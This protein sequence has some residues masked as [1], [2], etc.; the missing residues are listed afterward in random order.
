VSFT[1]VFLRCPSLFATVLPLLLVLSGFVALILRPLCC[2]CIAI[3]LRSVCRDLS[4]PI[5]VLCVAIA[6]H[7]IFVPF[8]AIY[9]DPIF[10]LCVAIASHPIFVCT[11]GRNSDAVRYCQSELQRLLSKTMKTVCIDID[12]WYVIIYTTR[13]DKNEMSKLY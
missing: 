2:D 1:I 13:A 3:H 11:G 10:V 9:R 7:P 5:F 6:S 4:H 8:V 12:G